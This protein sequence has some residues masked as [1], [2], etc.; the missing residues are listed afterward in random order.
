VT[1]ES[2]E[3][4]EPTEGVNIVILRK[5]VDLEILRRRSEYCHCCVRGFC[6]EGFSIEFGTIYNF[7]EKVR[8]LYCK[9]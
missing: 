7:M 1:V 8:L 6:F 2:G 3:L 5:T 9:K 4:R